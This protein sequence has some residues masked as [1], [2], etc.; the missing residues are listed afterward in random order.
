[1][2]I[3]FAAAE[4]VPFVKTGGLADVVGSLPKALKGLDIDVSVMLPCYK[5]VDS[6]FREEM[7]EVKSIEVPVGWR[8]QYCNIK[9]LKYGEITYYFLDNEY[10]FHRDGLYGHMDDGERF[11]FYSRAILESLVALNLKPKIIHCHD[12]HTALVNVFLKTHYKD[13]DF[14]S[15]MKS[16]LTVH[17]LKYQGVYPSEVLDDLLSLG[18]EHFTLDGLEFYGKVNYMKGGLSYADAITT[19]STTYSKEIQYPFFGENLHGVLKQRKNVLYGILNGI[20]YDDY[21]PGKDK[22]IFYNYNRSLIKKKKNKEKLQ[23]LLGLQINKDIPMLAMVYRLVRQKGLDLIC[24]V[25][26]DILSS[27]VQMVVLGTG[28]ESYE[29]YFKKLAHKYPQ[30]V[31]ANI[32]FDDVLA[33][34]IYA[35]SDMFLMPSL[36]EPCGISQLIALK[37]GSIPIVRETGGLK[38]TVKAYNKYTQEGNGFSFSMFNA[39]DMRYTVNLGLKHYEDGETWSQIVNNA[40]SSD[41]SWKKSADEYK[42]LYQELTGF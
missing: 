42:S 22:N 18:K 36:F 15:G 31:S 26:E 10:Y 39:H 41:Y 9:K 5:A 29:N 7:E 27:D 25:A 21:N 32:L 1:M 12:W 4:C 2:E 33:R 23:E 16:I 34:R 17:N 40:V 28:E 8:R 3:L 30:K 38:D 19:V 6:Q 37:Y 20:D 35:G 14:F 11:A 24:N 13:N